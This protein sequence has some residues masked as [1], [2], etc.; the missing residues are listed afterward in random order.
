MIDKILLWHIDNKNTNY[1]YKYVSNIL[2]YIFSISFISILWLNIYAMFKNHIP[3]FINFIMIGFIFGISIALYT[4]VVKKEI[5]EPEEKKTNFDELKNITNH[6]ELKHDS[7]R[8]LLNNLM[9]MIDENSG[10]C[11]WM[12]DHEDKYIYADSTLRNMLL[13]GKELHEVVGRSDTELAFNECTTATYDELSDMLKDFP[14]ERLPEL[15]KE[16]FEGGL[17][18][19]ITDVITRMFRKPCRYHEEVA[20]Y[21]LDVW[22]TPVINSKNQVC[23][24]VGSLVDVT[25]YK[26]ERKDMIQSLINAKL[27][28]RIDHT[29]NFYIKKYSFGSLRELLNG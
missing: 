10:V 19:N 2:T 25:K 20:G 27:A 15:P 11:M 21:V 16:L 6:F 18:C 8:R 1:I 3:E 17:V 9:I 13:G 12:K 7:M 26:Y 29:N 23:G 22:K 24:T 14:E 28:Y 4:S 5:E